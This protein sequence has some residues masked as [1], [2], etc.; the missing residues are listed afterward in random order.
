MDDNPI[1]GRRQAVGGEMTT[2]CR[3]VRGGRS[4]TVIVAA[5]YTLMPF[6]R[7]ERSRPYF[8]ACLPSSLLNYSV[9]VSALPAGT[10]GCC[11]DEA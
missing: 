8:L 5:L 9:S 11:G 7:Y 4:A 6:L 1:L 3:R 10:A 2:L